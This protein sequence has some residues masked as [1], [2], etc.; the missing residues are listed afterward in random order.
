MDILKDD[1]L[2]CLMGVFWVVLQCFLYWVGR[3][4]GFYLFQEN[5][6]FRSYS[7][8]VDGLDDY[9]LVIVFQFFLKVEDVEFNISKREMQQ[10][11]K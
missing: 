11:K 9:W 2:G 7:L 3:E 6:N 4:F 1:L 8:I 5:E 10:W